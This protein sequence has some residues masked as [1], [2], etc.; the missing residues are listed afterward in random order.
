MVAVVI[1]ALGLSLGSGG[2]IAGDAQAEL[3]EQA[4]A[5][6]REAACTRPR[7]GRAGTGGW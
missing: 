7:S 1:C 2:L 3:R 4:A 5:A 6:M